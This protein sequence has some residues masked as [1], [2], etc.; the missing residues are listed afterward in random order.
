MILL[1]HQGTTE[2]TWPA[3]MGRRSADY[4]AEIMLKMLK[5]DNTIVAKR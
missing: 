3:R 2:I 1:P 4:R 5:F